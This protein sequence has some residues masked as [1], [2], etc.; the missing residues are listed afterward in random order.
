MSS[1]ELFS[2][3]L[4]QETSG[5]HV[6]VIDPCCSSTAWWCAAVQSSANICPPYEKKNAFPYFASQTAC[7]FTPCLTEGREC[8]PASVCWLHPSEV[9]GWSGHPALGTGQ[10][11][12]GHWHLDPTVRRQSPRVLLL[13]SCS[14][15]AKGDLLTWPSSYRVGDVQQEWPEVF[16]QALSSEGTIWRLAN[17]V[18]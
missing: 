11:A 3:S 6:S 13:Q 17:K 1:G 8:I 9:P 10:A 5:F 12:P 14:W 15:P 2:C 4:S 7:W 16:Q 18:T